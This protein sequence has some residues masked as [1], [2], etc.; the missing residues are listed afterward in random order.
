MNAFIKIFAPVGLVIGLAWFA[1]WVCFVA[2]EVLEVR[3]SVV[4]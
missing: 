1:W 2:A 4:H 3:G